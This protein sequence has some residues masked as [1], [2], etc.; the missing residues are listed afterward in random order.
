MAPH[1]TILVA[2]LLLASLPLLPAAAS[3]EVLLGMSTALTGPAAELGHNM[4][5]GVR[6]GLAR[7]NRAG[8]VHDRHLR[9]IALDDG[10]EATREIRRREHP[11]IHLPIIA[12]TANAMESDREA[13]LAAGMDDFLSKPVQ[14]AALAAT[15]ARWSGSGDG[16]ATAE[17]EPSTAPT[18]AYMP[19]TSSSAT[20]SSVP[21]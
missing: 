19:S 16:P 18:A 21:G 12:M 5:D 3:E 10:Y 15:L 8:G 14:R 11:G 13:C 6:A 2:L 20:A 17:R 7:A 1:R 9:L 4:L